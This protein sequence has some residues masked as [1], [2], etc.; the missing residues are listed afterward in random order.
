MTIILETE[1]LILR[2]IEP[3]DAPFLHALLT[4]ADFRANIGHRG[5]D[6]IEDAVR[7]IPERYHAIYRAH[8]FGMWVVEPRGGGAPL[9]MAGLVRRDGLDDVDLGYAFLPAARGHGYALEAARGV[10]AWA[11]AHAIDPVVAIVSEGNAG[12]IRVLERL[13]LVADR[14][15]R[16]PGGTHDV[17]LYRPKDVA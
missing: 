12:S 1:R 4:D 15:I 6:T 17:M 11:A 16:L 3:G 13:G 2:E 10:L 8:G 5:V 7:V 9:G 14:L